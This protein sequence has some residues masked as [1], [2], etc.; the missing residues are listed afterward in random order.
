MIL[1][2][3]RA[4]FQNKLTE[5]I[6][7]PKHLW[8]ALKALGF[9]NKVSSCEVKVLKINSIFENSVNSVLERFN[10]YYSALEENLVKLL[11]KPPNKNL[12]NTVIFILLKDGV[13]YSSKLISD[14]CNLSITSEKFLDLSRVAKL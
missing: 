9:P 5:S 1:N 11:P 3:K 7:N 10:S 8:K 6:G 12:I 2:K 14:L 13:K 4:L